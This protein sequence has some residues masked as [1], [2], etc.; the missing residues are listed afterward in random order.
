MDN[1]QAAILV[2][3]SANAAL[4]VKVAVLERAPPGTP[5]ALTAIQ[6]AAIGSAAGAAAAAMAPQPG[7]YDH[8][9]DLFTLN[10]WEFDRATLSVDCFVTNCEMCFLILE[11]FQMKAQGVCECL[12]NFQLG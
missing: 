9:K 7:A 10:S 8:A 2:L 6:L 3:H 1:I 5:A 4:L 12:L 11:K